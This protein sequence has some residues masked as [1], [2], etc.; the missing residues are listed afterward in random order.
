MTEKTILSKFAIALTLNLYITK[1]SSCDSLAMQNI[2]MKYE[3]SRMN[4]TVRNTNLMH[5]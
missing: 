1:L 4:S 5:L 2:Y 3:L